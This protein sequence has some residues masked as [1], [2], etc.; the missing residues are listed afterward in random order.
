MAVDTNTNSV[1][2]D[3]NS[4]DSIKN[5]D[6]YGLAVGKAIYNANKAYL[7]LRNERFM[8][9]RLYYKGR[10]PIGPYLSLLNVNGKEAFIDIN[11]KPRPIAKKFVK[12]IVEGYMNKVE[13]PSVSSINPLVADRKQDVIDR[14]KWKISEKEWINKVQ[15][16]AQMQ[17][18]DPSAYLPS[19][20]EEATFYYS[21]NNKQREELILEMMIQFVMNDNDYKEEK[22]KILKDLVIHNVS[23]VEDWIDANGRLRFEAIPAEELIYG[24]SKRE[25]FDDSPYKARY[26]RMSVADFRNIPG[27]DMTEDQIYSVAKSFAN[28]NSNGTVNYPF[29]PTFSNMT[30]RPYD[31]NV[32]DIIRFW[33][34]T[35]RNLTYVEGV[36]KNN[37]TIFDIKDNVSQKTNSNKKIG[38]KPIMVG[39]TGVWVVGTD[40]IINWGMEKNMLKR[41][42]ALQKIESP[43]SVFMIDNDGDMDSKSMVE[44]MISSIMEMDLDILKIQQIK[45]QQAPNGLLIDVEGLEDIDLGLGRGALKPLQLR[46]IRSQQGDVYYRSKNEPGDASQGP[47]VKELKGDFGNLLQEL[48][49]DYNFNLGNIRDYIG[50]NEYRDGSTVNP[51]TGLGVQQSQIEQSNNATQPIYSALVNLIRKLNRHIALRI[52]DAI[53]NGTSA[54]AYK[55]ILGDDN[56][57]FIQES[58][59]I[60]ASLY[61][62]D[63]ELDLSDQEKANLEQ[64][65]QIAINNGLID[66]KDLAALNTMTNA[67]YAAQYLAII[68]AK[69][70]AEQQKMALANSEANAQAQAQSIGLKAQADQA[71]AQIQ[72][73]S[74]VAVIEAKTQ[75]GLEKA[76]V[77]FYS[78]MQLQSF[79]L[80]KEL[81]PNIQQEIDAYNQEQKEMQAY[82]VQQM[83]QQ[84]A[85]QAQQQQ[86]AQAQQQQQGQQNPNAINPKSIQTQ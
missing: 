83:Q 18:E 20:V 70:K 73:Q 27:N 45:A 59:D 31:D 6:A 44:D 4:P 30:I 53:K 57:A 29:S 15:E 7:N 14:A 28:K 39:Y 58:D 56:V 61:D 66:I 72:A 51:K 17:L 74:A 37:R 34:K 8:Q 77:D 84:Q 38:S 65:K 80:G 33:Y 24:P 2:P 76:K 25:D 41:D 47:P 22:R 67:K 78:N 9:A 71:I 69:N 50:V 54:D 42:D 16:Q 21:M 81:P 52:W 13:K 85:Q 26:K 36:D 3:P 11:F 23:G 5:T 35:N 68:A 10:Q 79:I 82:A 40:F 60:T 63:I 43:I 32:I 62:V 86:Q 1:F 64:E 48:I 49:A 46:E 75:G 12:I 19:T 55:K